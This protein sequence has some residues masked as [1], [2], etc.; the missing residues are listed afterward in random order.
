[1]PKR[2]CTVGKIPKFSQKVPVACHL[3]AIGSQG[4]TAAFSHGTARQK[5]RWSIPETAPVIYL[6]FELGARE[7]YVMG[8]I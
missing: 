2:K 4:R 1:M 8:T 6:L 5:E 7:R 3:N